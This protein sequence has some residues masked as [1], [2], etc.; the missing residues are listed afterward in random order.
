MAP[1]AWV[2]VAAYA[3]LVGLAWC[4]QHLGWGF[5]PGPGL[6][7]LLAGVAAILASMSVG[8]AIGIYQMIAGTRARMLAQLAEVRELTRA[9]LA[10]GEPLSPVVI[11]NARRFRLVLG[12]LLTLFATA[13]LVAGSW[14]LWA[15]Q[16][17]RGI[18]PAAQ[19]AVLVRLEAQT[20]QVQRA[21][22]KTA[23][24]DKRR[25]TLEM[26]KRVLAWISQMSP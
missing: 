5:L 23:P 9:V 13:C 2:L 6:M 12:A 14:V 3:L 19:D 17:G 20:N 1:L 18:P 22:D 21:I 10:A 25:Q 24:G 15:W 8:S 16:S 11:R 4:G 26:E 7:A